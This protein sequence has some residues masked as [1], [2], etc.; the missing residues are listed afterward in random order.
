M[1]TKTVSLST[2]GKI[3]IDA[4]VCLGAYLAAVGAG[5]PGQRVRTRDHATTQSAHSTWFIA[6]K[7]VAGASATR[8]VQYASHFATALWQY[9]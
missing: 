3:V 2:T 9:E 1:S 5:A 4:A 8:S 6:R 7:P